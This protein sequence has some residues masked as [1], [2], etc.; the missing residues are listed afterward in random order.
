MGMAWATDLMR[1]LLPAQD[2]HLLRHP[3]SLASSLSCKNLKSFERALDRNNGAPKY[4]ESFLSPFI[5]RNCLIS[6]HFCFWQCLEKNT[7]DLLLFK[8]WPDQLQYVSRKWFMLAASLLQALENNTMSSAYITWVM[9]G[10]PT[11]GN[12]T[13]QLL[14]PIFSSLSKDLWQAEADII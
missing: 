7:L 12:C 1:V 3:I 13:I 5:W 9:V 14:L 8:L 6:L 2:K 11:L 10:P 4:I